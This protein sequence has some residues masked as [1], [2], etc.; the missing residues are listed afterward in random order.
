MP[1]EIIKKSFDIREKIRGKAK[2]HAGHSKALPVTL[3]L[4]QPGRLRVGHM[5]TLF[6]VS[7][8]GFYA[9]L[10]SKYPSPDGYD[11]KRP[12]WKTGTALAALN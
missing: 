8:S 11:G 10:G 7:H 12:Y 4:H 9:G 2:Q 1:I 6:G 3:D 5:L